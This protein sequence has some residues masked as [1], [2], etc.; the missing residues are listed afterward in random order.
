ML[1]TEA[2]AVLPGM[3]E[4][5]RFQAGPSEPDTVG[6]AFGAE[7]AKPAVHGYFIG[8]RLFCVAV[9]AAR[10]PQVMLWGRELTA[11]VPTDLER[12]LLHAPDCEVLDVSYGP[13]GNPGAA[14]IGLVL[15]VQ[16]V[17]GK[18]MTRPVTVGR[19][20]EDRCPDDWEGPIPECEW[21][22]RQWPYPGYAD[23]WPPPGHAPAWS[24]WQPPFQAVC[25]EN[26]TARR[27]A[28]D[29]HHDRQ[30]SESAAAFTEIAPEPVCHVR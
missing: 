25:Q 17:E 24:D 21:I 14:R 3:S 26:R 6:V 28:T 11:C 4:L 13:R 19:G 10:G 1:I 23:Y 27:S 20:W 12:F 18:V 29:T 30:S 9:D 16:E 22:G 15:R 8:D 2:A 5:C 7:R